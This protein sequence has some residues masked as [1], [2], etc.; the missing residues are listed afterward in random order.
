MDI[1]KQLEIIKRGAVE[2][3]SEE[4]LKKKLACGGT[5]KD[6]LIELQ[7]HHKKKIKPILIAH[8][9]REEM[10]EGI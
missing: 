5:I 9:Y 10:I 8:G 7:G 1:A 6:N 3:I 4:E 2:I